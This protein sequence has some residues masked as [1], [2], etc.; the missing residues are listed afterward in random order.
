MLRWW[1]FCRTPVLEKA[2]KS[3]WELILDGN[4]LGKEISETVE[5]VYRRLSGLDLPVPPSQSQTVNVAHP[6]ENRGEESEKLKEAETPKQP[7]A[8]K[9][10]F[11]E[12]SMQ[13]GAET[14]ANGCSDQRAV[15]TDN[16]VASGTNQS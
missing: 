10:S 14:V 1:K 15:A 11:G 12:M 5:R 16:G 7:S 2:S 8:R 9:R 13:D 3:V 6:E 4:G